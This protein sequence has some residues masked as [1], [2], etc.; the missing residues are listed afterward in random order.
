MATDLTLTKSAERMSLD[1]MIRLGDIFRKSGY[2]RDIRE[3]AQ[4][5]TKILFGQELGFTPVVSL[6]GIYIVDG[7]PCLSG[8]LLGAMVKRSGRYDYK[9][10]VTTNTECSIQFTQNGE[11]LGVSTFTMDDAKTAGIAAKDTWRKY[12]KAM[13]FNRALSAGI[14]SFCPDISVCPVYV[15]EE[16][17][18]EV[19]MEG[20]VV[21]APPEHTVQQDIHIVRTIPNPPV[22]NPI[23]DQITDDP[24]PDPIPE[25]VYVS[26]KQAKTLHMRFK[27]EL[28]DE[29]KPKADLF[30][31]DFL[32]QRG[33]VDAEGHPSAKMI[34]LTDYLKAGKDAM[35][36]AHGLGESEKEIRL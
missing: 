21:E 11:L 17:G 27:E 12:P 31:Y 7:K 22:T 3:E 34:P 36:L 14:R 2:F 24:I 25:T 23:H 10:Q 13:L 30:L 18:A 4:A 28:P 29:L 26:T 6:M 33:Y 8:N 9:V 35:A 1:Q 20:E 5:V 15:P 32:K 19:N 16:M